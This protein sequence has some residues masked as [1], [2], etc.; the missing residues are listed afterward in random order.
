ME[1]LLMM[2]SERG[3]GK[4]EKVANFGAGPSK[5]PEQ[6]VLQLCDDLLDWNNTGVGILEV[7]HRSKEF[8][9][10][11]GEAEA[12]L[13][14]IIGIPEDYAV[15]FMQGGGTLQFSAVVMNLVSKDPAKDTVD[16]LVSGTWSKKASQEATNLLSGT[17]ITVN[18]ITIFKTHDKSSTGSA[19]PE[20]VPVPEWTLSGDRAAYVYYCENETIDGI[21]MPTSDFIADVMEAR[22]IDAP[23]V[24][25]MS[26]NFLSRPIHVERF[27]LIFAT[28]QKNFGPAGATVVIVSRRLLRSEISPLLS[29]PTIFDYRIFDKN[30][31]LYNTPPSLA[32]NTCNLVFKWMVDTFGTLQ[33]LEKFSMQKSTLLYKCIL[34][35]D[36]FYCTIVPPKFQSRMNAVFRICGAEGTVSC[37]LEDL[38]IKESE[39]HGLLQLRGHRSVRGIRV[40]LYNAVTVEETMRACNFMISFAATHRFK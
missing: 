29:V 25:D 5:L 9:T 39:A 3:E 22:R 17:Q 14:K 13:R 12:R 28:A 2:P 8:S 26:S 18:D 27:G 10:M 38:F 21:E 33:E 24:A 35:S 11:M 32:I 4:S 20:F 6:V 1:F 16:Y 37:D 23:L 15:L 31:S 40:S 30:H 34:E 19:G 36:G 7:S